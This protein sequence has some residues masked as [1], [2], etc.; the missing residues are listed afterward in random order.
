MKDIRYSVIIP[1]LHS[2]SIGEVLSAL[3][4]QTG[5]ESGM[6]IIVV[7]RDKFG[8]VKNEDTVRFLESE[9]DLSAAE[10]RNRGINN[11]QG[12]IIFFLDA[13]CIP[14]KDWMCR[15]LSAYKKGYSFAG[16]AVAFEKDTFWTLCDNISHF[17]LLYP[18]TKRGTAQNFNIHT[19]NMCIAKKILFKV[20]G[21]DERFPKAGGE[22]FDLGMRVR[23]AGYMPFFEPFAVVVHKPARSSFI[24]FIK[25][26]ADW[27]PYSIFLRVLY[28][29]ILKT[30]RVFLYWP[31]LILFSPLISSYVTLK[32]FF[33]HPPL[34][35]YWYTM[36]FVFIDKIAW[37]LISARELITRN[38]HKRF[39]TA[40]GKP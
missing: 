1:T 14:E 2:P 30:P 23:K 12:D 10:A 27:A 5:I 6:E 15:L 40:S 7:G 32:I 11:A 29:D 24:S 3:K 18:G 34:L 38:V 26:T 17:G 33:A 19:A 13:D 8:I 4:K 31:L 25:H 39:L 20:N 21:F 35:K 16:G 22:D 37:C 36:P 9:K 28:K